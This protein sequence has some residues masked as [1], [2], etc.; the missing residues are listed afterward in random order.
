MFQQ[1][2]VP[3]LG[4]VE[5]LSYMIAPKSKERIDV[6]GEGGGK[7]TAAAMQVAFLGELPL[8]PQVRV[9]GDSGRPPALLGESD[10]TATGF[11]EL[12]RAVAAAGQKAA[13]SAKGPSISIED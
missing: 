12:A 7:R 13:A 3:V 5:N 2:R 11:Y 6:F 10:A 4:I 1:V 8:D 9:G